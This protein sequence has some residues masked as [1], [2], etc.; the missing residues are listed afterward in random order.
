MGGPKDT[1]ADGRQS[2][3]IRK[4]ILEKQSSGLG[5]VVYFFDVSHVC[6][7]SRNIKSFTRPDGT[8]F[9]SRSNTI[10]TVTSP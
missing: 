3:S 6:D 5:S 8:H 10:A 4:A 2:V 1:S 7:K 9:A